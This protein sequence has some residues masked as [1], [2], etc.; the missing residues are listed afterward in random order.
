L[1]K[2]F[3]QSDDVN[4][5]RRLGEVHH[6]RVDAAVRVDGEIFGPEVLSGVVESVIVEE[7][8]AQDGTLGVDIRWKTADA[9]FESC[10]DV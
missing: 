9:G 6:A 7:D 3:D 1:L 5:P 8:G 2:F 4:G 10:H